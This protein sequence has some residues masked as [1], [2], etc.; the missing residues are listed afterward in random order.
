[1]NYHMQ[2]QTKKLRSMFMSADSGQHTD[3]DTFI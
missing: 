1:M 3:Y 2:K